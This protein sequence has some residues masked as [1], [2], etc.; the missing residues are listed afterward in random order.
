MAEV[1]GS[2]LSYPDLLPLPTT[3]SHARPPRPRR[4]PPRVTHSLWGTVSQEPRKSFLQTSP[5]PQAV[6]GCSAAQAWCLR[7]LSRLAGL[8]GAG[9]QPERGDDVHGG[10]CIQVSGCKSWPPAPHLLYLLN[11]MELQFPPPTNGHHS[12]LWGS[13]PLVRVRS[14]IP[15]AV[16]DSGE[17]LL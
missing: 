14:V 9:A 10:L 11:L 4:L 1:W 17:C 15:R 8:A 5:N 13:R 16:P 2:V 12:N 7:F 6:V 3:P